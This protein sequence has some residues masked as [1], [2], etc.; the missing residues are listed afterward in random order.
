[1]RRQT[2]TL[3]PEAQHPGTAAAGTPRP[4][5]AAEPGGQSPGGPARTPR[6]ATAVPGP[7][8]LPAALHAHATA[9]AGA[10]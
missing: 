5:T 10:G 3:T 1:M 6:P 2:T 8:G 4:T 7:R 9:P